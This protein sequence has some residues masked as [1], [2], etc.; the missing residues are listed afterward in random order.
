[1][2]ARS[3]EAGRAFMRLTLDD[4]EFQRGIKNTTRSLNRLGA[5][6][7]GFGKRFLALGAGL[8]APLT[9]AVKLAADSQETF[10][11]FDVV[12]GS[13]AKA[14]RVFGDELASSLGRSETLVG[15]FLAGFQDL[16]VPIGID[17]ATAEETSKL[18]T[19]LTFDL[20]SFNNKADP[21]VLRDLQAALTGS[22]EVMKKYG[23]IV[24]EAAVKQQLLED[25]I[26][27]SAVTEQEKVFAR[28]KIILAG[29]T[30][31]QGDAAR[32]AGSL[33]NRMKAL[34]GAAKDFGVEIGS[35][36]LKPLAQITGVVTDAIKELRTFAKTN[37]DL[38]A[39]YAIAAGG[40]LVVG[41][42]LVTLGVGFLIASAAVSGFAAVI[43]GVVTAV[44]FLLSPL[45]LIVTAVVAAGAAFLKFSGVGAKLVDSLKKG[46]AELSAIVGDTFVVIRKAL[47]GGDLMAAGKALF[48]GLKVI[49]LKGVAALANI[50]APVGAGL[51]NA[52]QTAVGAVVKLFAVLRQVWAN[53]VAGMRVAW[54][55]FTGFVR[56]TWAFAQRS[57]TDGVLRTQKFIT[58]K[59][60][61]EEFDISVE[62]NQNNKAFD[63]TIKNL[64]KEYEK[65]KDL[66]GKDLNNDL[67]QIETE[68]GIA[69]EV[70]AKRGENLQE[71]F[72]AKIDAA[73][74]NADEARK[75]LQDMAK[76][77]R[78]G[79]DA[80]KKASSGGLFDSIKKLTKGIDAQALSLGISRSPEGTFR[81]ATAALQFGPSFD[82]EK[83][84]LAVANL[85]LA[86]QKK[87]NAIAKKKQEGVKV[88]P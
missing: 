59:L 41:G 71:R 68:R 1:M 27:V 75:N 24:S 66:I 52:W 26:D 4:Q 72:N 35:A 20:A 5:T 30:A 54:A 44:G 86:E 64:R 9:A 73:Q 16:L 38:V 32:T 48:A 53:I 36:I 55:A 82:I 74:K 12:F 49:F 31:A 50:F 58:E 10:S 33:T 11:K 77:A 7:A 63:N 34:G 60:T 22:G 56:K 87:A 46:F 15:S 37:K 39:I 17:P 81:G 8:A 45:G 51:I 80:T 6:I 83:R 13:S 40:A 85:Q 25:G 78:D 65:T 67:N 23:V 76:A 43:G 62:L 84:Q 57:V 3:I 18:L 21:S 2:G 79:A 47:K 19:E 14:V 70:L 42:A 69:L 88:A 61:G 29:T 28:L